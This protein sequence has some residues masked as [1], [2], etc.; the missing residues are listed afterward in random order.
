MTAKKKNFTADDIISKYMDYVL[1]H[2]HE[3]VSIYKFCKHQEIPE[4]QF[5][6]VAGSFDSLRKT[7]WKRFFENTHEV[8][9][10]SDGFE[11]LSA[12]DKML[13]MFYTLFEVFTANRSYVLYSL[14]GKKDKM[15]SLK[16]LSELR[17]VIKEFA[18]E[19]IQE[20]NDEKQL[21]ILW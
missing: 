6:T 19:L 7:I 5:Y 2:E 20:S 21:R 12:K 11:G 3:P 4:D 15:K 17:K 1:E 14:Q 16:E 13:T 8:M 10:K 18:G 9:L